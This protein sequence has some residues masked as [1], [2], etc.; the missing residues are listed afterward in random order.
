MGYHVKNTTGFRL[1]TCSD[2]DIDVVLSQTVI[3]D[4][5]SEEF[6]YTFGYYIF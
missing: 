2:Y 4:I 3:I 6:I 5:Y 1:N